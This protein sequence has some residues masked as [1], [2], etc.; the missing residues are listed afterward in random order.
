MDKVEQRARELLAEAYDR[1]GLRGSY[2]IANPD[3]PKPD[4]TDE[5][6]YMVVEAACSAIAAA[7]R[8][9]ARARGVLSNP[10][11]GEPR[12]YRDVNS[13]PEGVLCVEPGAPLKAAPDRSGLTVKA[14]VVPDGYVLVPEKFGIPADAWG[15]AAFAYGGPATGEG[16]NYMDCTAWVGYIEDDDG[17]KRY[18]LHVSCDECPEEGSITVA[19]FPEASPSPPVEQSCTCPSGD[20]SLR[21]PCPQ[22]PPVEQAARGGVDGAMVPVPRWF[23]DKLALDTADVGMPKMSAAI[24]A[25]AGR[26]GGMEVYQWRRFANRWEDMTQE[27]YDE[28]Q[29]K[30]EIV[31]GDEI[32][33]PSM[34]RKLYAEPPSTPVAH[35]RDSRVDVEDRLVRAML[36]H[37]A[38]LTGERHG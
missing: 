38:A 36:D 3:A 20:G 7:L 28:A 11:T 25:L 26:P 29:A 10:W 32:I 13:D 2:Y 22:H 35:C 5:P 8:E 16:E 30:G 6:E 1:C 24:K 23:L 37:L 18:G 19:E 21:W 14:V 17:A 33:T 34:T 12:D 15:A 31:I 4:V 27:Q 9:Q